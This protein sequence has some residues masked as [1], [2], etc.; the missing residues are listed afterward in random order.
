MRKPWTE[1]GLGKPSEA[2]SESRGANVN[3]DETIFEP[4]ISLNNESRTISLTERNKSYREAIKLNAN[5]EKAK[6]QEAKRKD[7]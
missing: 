5:T 3:E 7:K 4:E 1:R 6:G 2:R